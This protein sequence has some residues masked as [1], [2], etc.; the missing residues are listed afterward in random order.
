MG[1]VETPAP[2]R[3][4]DPPAPVPW[5]PAS[6]PPPPRRSGMV[7]PV[8]TAVLALIA[9]VATGWA[10]TLHRDVTRLAQDNAALQA[11]VATYERLLGGSPEDWFDDSF[12][13]DPASAQPLNP[14]A[15]VRVE[16]S[17]SRMFEVAS[18]DGDLLIATL[19]PA[20]P[21]VL[22]ELQLYDADG[23]ALGDAWAEDI[24]AERLEL[25]HLFV[26]DD[27]VY[28][29]ASPYESGDVLLTVEVV[30]LG[31]SGRVLD[32]EL[33][34]D[35]LPSRLPIEVAGGQVLDVPGRGGRAHDR[36]RHHLGRRPRGGAA[37][38]R[39]RRRGRPRR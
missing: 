6:A 3:N 22:L 4:P 19:E 16:G 32:V 38:H 17:G 37:A 18:S 11:E 39:R 1:T 28:L 5:G 30:G 26:G 12:G 21:G 9:V 8:I 2:P 7:L 31:P 29:I 10:L 36:R 34:L 33:R 35:E 13:F 20:A 14:G 25:H 15:A 27:P 24:D 23:L